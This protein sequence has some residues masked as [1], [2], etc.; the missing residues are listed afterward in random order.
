MLGINFVLPQIFWAMSMTNK[1]PKCFPEPEKFDPSRF[2]EKEHLPYTFLPF[3][4]G[5]R[6]CAG[7]EYARMAILIF[8]HNTVTKFKWDLLYPDEKILG[9]LVLPAPVKGLPIRLHPLSSSISPKK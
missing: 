4:A 5:L 6:M 3:G 1:D 2:M 9:G 7:V 8:F